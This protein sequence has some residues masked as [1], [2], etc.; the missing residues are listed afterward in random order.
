MKKTFDQHCYLNKLDEI[1]I[2]REETMSQSN[3][4][5]KK[6]AQK[7]WHQHSKNSHRSAKKRLTGGDNN[8]KKRDNTSPKAK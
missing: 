6:G 1:P 5:R 7:V 4:Q 3:R 8:K 2:D